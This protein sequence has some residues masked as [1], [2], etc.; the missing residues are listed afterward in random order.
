MQLFKKLISGF[1]FGI[2]FSLAF[3]IVYTV[4]IMWA[5]PNA[6]NDTP[7]DFDS[8]YQS[9]DRD[10]NRTTT[11]QVPS[12]IKAEGF[13]GSTGSYS[14]DFKM[15]NFEV[16]SA[17]EGLITGQVSANGKPIQGLKLRLGLNQQ[18]MTQWTTSNLDGDYTISV[19]YGEYRVDAYQLDG[20]T[21]DF[22]LSG[23]INHPGNQI[24]RKPVLV[25]EGL[26]GKGPSFEFVTPVKKL[27]PSGAVS[28]VGDLFLEWEPYPMASEY[29][30]QIYQIREPGEYSSVEALFDFRNRPRVTE[31]K[32]SLVKHEIISEP[33]MSYRFEVVAYDSNDKRL[34]ET[35]NDYATPDFQ[36]L[37]SK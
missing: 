30:I 29:E 27:S 14:G 6:F 4:W 19:P 37:S 2:G 33:G 20:R 15:D 10:Q 23:T 25:A 21:A 35:A 16:I 34:S 3:V 8:E 36:I 32:F 28:I 31:P 24:L 17:G 9:A 22:K 18:V 1:A 7:P 5:L 11:S 26:I 13:L 12:L